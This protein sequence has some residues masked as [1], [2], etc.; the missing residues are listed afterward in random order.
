MSVAKQG[1][2]GTTATALTSLVLQGCVKGEGHT[3]TGFTLPLALADGFT[4]LAHALLA[5]LAAGVV[6]QCVP[7]SVGEGGREGVSLAATL[8]GGGGGAAQ[9]DLN[10]VLN[11]LGVGNLG[12]KSGSGSQGDHHIPP[13][14]AHFFELLDRAL[15]AV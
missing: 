4:A 6:L 15:K 2:W 12:D 8:G 9:D 3:T 10:M 1:P 7:P 14:K 11:L 13:W 5:P